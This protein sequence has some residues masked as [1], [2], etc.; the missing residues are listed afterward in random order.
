VNKTHRGWNKK[1]VSWWCFDTFSLA[2]FQQWNID[3]VGYNVFNFWEK[4]GE[5]Q[6]F[7]L[8]SLS[9]CVF[10]LRRKEK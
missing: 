5:K 1:V 4:W 2:D 7:R 6:L 3:F 8:L 10:G 9:R